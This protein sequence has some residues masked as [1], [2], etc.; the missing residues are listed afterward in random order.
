[1]VYNTLYNMKKVNNCWH[2]L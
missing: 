2:M 1:M